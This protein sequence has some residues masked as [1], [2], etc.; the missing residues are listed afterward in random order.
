MESK[1][2]WITMEQ[3]HKLKERAANKISERMFK[4]KK[5]CHDLLK[6][7]IDYKT[8]KY[9]EDRINIYDFDVRRDVNG[10]MQMLFFKKRVDWLVFVDLL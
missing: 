3:K 5:E 2:Q 9:I 10:A 1:A 6:E 4:I 8:Y 7:K